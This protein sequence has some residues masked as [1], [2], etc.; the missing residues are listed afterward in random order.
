MQ[1]ADARRM[2]LRERLILIKNYVNFKTSY[3][4][5]TLPSRVAWNAIE[6][7]KKYAE[8]ALAQAIRQVGLNGDEIALLHTTGPED[9]WQPFHQ[10]T[11]KFMVS[12]AVTNAHF[13]TTMPCD[14]I[15]QLEKLRRLEVIDKTLWMHAKLVHQFLATLK[16][17]YNRTKDVSANPLRTAA[18]KSAA[19]QHAN[20]RMNSTGDDFYMNDTDVAFCL[21]LQL[22]LKPTADMPDECVC[23]LSLAAFNGREINNHLMTCNTNAAAVTFAHN[24]VLRSVAQ[25]CTNAGAQT[26]VEEAVMR[27][28]QHRIH[29]YAAWA[30]RSILIDVVGT[31]LKAHQLGRLGDGAIIMQFAFERQGRLGKKAL[32]SIKFCLGKRVYASLDI[33]DSIQSV[34]HKPQRKASWIQDPSGQKGNRGI[35]A[36]W[37]IWAREKGLTGKGK[38]EGSRITSVAT[39]APRTFYKGKRGG[40]CDTATALDMS[41]PLEEERLCNGGE[42]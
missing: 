28:T 1:I 6:S 42:T 21:A 39:A 33:T 16:G 30:E 40:D 12:S 27:S 41:F 25:M 17:K 3:I 32:G 15:L 19:P 2:P 23:G 7:H 34:R 35:G 37:A 20:L 31:Q 8:V 24:M 29:I 9:L 4:A 10:H 26:N 38:R 22:G 5:S 36:I 11:Y 13:L 18:V 14:P